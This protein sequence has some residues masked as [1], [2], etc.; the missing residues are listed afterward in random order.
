M[1][2]GAT[3]AIQEISEE[4]IEEAIE[5]FGRLY[6]GWS[7]RRLGDLTDKLRRLDFNDLVSV[8]LS[9]RERLTLKDSE[10]PEDPRERYCY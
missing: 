3:D 2:H 5:A 1:E 9:C 6:P 8:L 10:E 7:S 4:Y